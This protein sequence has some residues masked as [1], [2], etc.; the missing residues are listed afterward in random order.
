MLH[1][2][3]RRFTLRHDPAATVKV[4]T[5]AASVTLFVNGQEVGTRPV[6]NRIASWPVTLRE[7]ENEI[8]V[9][10]GEV[11]DRV[12]WSYQKAPDMLA[13]PANP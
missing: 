13:G 8:E 10:A 5:N 4:Y 3:S 2:T 11:A 7:G 1:I 9:R 12:V 6:D